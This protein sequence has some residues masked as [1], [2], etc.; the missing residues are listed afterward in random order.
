M[1]ADAMSAE[2]EISRGTSFGIKKWS[3]VLQKRRLVKTMVV[4]YLANCAASSW[5]WLTKRDDWRSSSSILNLNK[6]MMESK[7]TETKMEVV[8][9][10]ISN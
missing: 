4:E 6:T 9:L 8:P 5:L 2:L 10:P 7:E 1:S 3:V